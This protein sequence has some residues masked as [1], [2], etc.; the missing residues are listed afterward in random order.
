MMM[1]AP[2][3]TFPLLLTLLALVCRSH[4][5]VLRRT[6]PAF[7]A[8]VEQ[9]PPLARRAPTT[10]HD[11][12]PDD[13]E[14]IM[15]YGDSLT[16]GTYAKGLLPDT[17]ELSH[18]EWRGVSYASGGDEGALTIANLIKYY[19]PGVRGASVGHHP[20]ELC[21]GLLCPPGVK[22]WTPELD[23]LNAARSG[24]FAENLPHEVEDYL[25]PQV[26]AQNIS[27][28]AFKYLHMQVGTNDVC[29]LCAT[30]I[31][32]PSADIFEASIRKSLE[33]MRA[34]IPNILVNI[35]GVFPSSQLYDLTLNQPDHCPHSG[36]LPNINISC[37]CALLPGIAGDAT[38]ALMDSLASQYN[39]RLLKIVQDYQK[40][41][42]PAFAATWQPG[43]VPLAKYPIESLSNVDCFHFSEP[44]HQRLAA[45]IWN[46]LPLDAAGRAEEFSWPDEP[47][48]RCIQPDDRIDT[49]GALAL[50][51]PKDC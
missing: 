42:Y 31:L 49:Q 8:N 21:F 32:P 51:P 6:P 7:V 43:N 22:G 24:A 1:N 38:R 35:V 23:N 50:P 18:E 5:A 16:A 26:K 17:P 2:L 29:Q 30:A 40:A 48:V 20:V 11:L 33:Y 41:N 25:V 10:V 9:C 44:M 45:G 14:V 39:E 19:N 15:S 46:R 34:H 12:R 4:A 28:A 36:D 13:F 3:T 37:S 47:A 27:D